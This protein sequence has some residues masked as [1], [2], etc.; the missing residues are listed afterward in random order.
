MFNVEPKPWPLL[1]RWTEKM[2]KRETQFVTF[3]PPA[4]AGLQLSVPVLLV[5]TPE[6]DLDQRPTAPMTPMEHII[7]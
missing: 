1:P 6:P 2:T 3:V 5:P 4:A 7:I